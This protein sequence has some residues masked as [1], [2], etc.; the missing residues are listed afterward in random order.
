V[1]VPLAPSLNA[2]VNNDFGPLSFSTFS[3]SFKGIA[4]HVD[5]FPLNNFDIVLCSFSFA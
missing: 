1:S 2:L 4:G 5:L 3:F